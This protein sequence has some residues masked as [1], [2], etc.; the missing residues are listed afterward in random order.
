MTDHVSLPV[1][2]GVFYSSVPLQT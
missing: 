1:T 2:W